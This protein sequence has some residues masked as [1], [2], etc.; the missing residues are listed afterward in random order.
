MLSATEVLYA[1]SLTDWCIWKST[2]FWPNPW[3]SVVVVVVVVVG[4]VVVV[5]VIVVVVHFHLSTTT[6]TN[7]LYTA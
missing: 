2:Y 7:L 3:L 1:I 6:T 5:V 4:V